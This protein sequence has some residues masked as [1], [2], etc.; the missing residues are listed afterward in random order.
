MSFHDLCWWPQSFWG[1][2][3][4]GDCSN[5]SDTMKWD[6]VGG[7]K[8]LEVPWCSQT[9]SDSVKWWFVHEWLAIVLHVPAIPSLH[10]VPDGAVTW[11]PWPTTMREATAHAGAQVSALLLQLSP[12]QALKRVKFGK[13]FILSLRMCTKRGMR[14]YCSK[15]LQRSHKDI[16]A[17]CGWGWDEHLRLN[18]LLFLLSS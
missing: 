10:R 12:L 5:I 8:P 3:H 17:G 14:F 16:E 1:M 15:G 4:Q 6:N 7:H 11:P 9:S 18:L 2:D 13:V